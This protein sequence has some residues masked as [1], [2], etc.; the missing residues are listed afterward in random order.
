MKLTNKTN[1]KNR[2]S[3]IKRNR[4]TKDSFFINKKIT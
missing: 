2:K 3:E 1:E 4:K